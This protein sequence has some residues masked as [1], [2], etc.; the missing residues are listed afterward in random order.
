MNE[1][2]A[3]SSRKTL[4]NGGQKASIRPVA[5]RL[6]RLALGCAL[7]S[8][9]ATT[10]VALVARLDFA[11]QAPAL[12]VA[13]ET[14]AAITAS[15]AAFLLLGRFRRT[16][17]LDELILSAGLTLLAISNFAFAAVPA[18]FDLHSN[19][20]SLWG[21]LFTGTLA[22]LLIAVAALLPRRRLAAGPRWPLVVYGS[23]VF[24]GVIGALL[25]AAFQNR[26]PPGVTASTTGGA[27]HP[28]LVVHPPVLTLQLVL[29][30]L[31]LLAAL[32]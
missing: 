1:R 27:S 15:A 17:F 31:Y 21:M 14:T 22:A 25:L 6:R 26:L 19:R 7:G 2:A 12:H 28:H 8:A 4:P 32:G 5:L 24:V 23:V 20:A 18:A 11:Y 29:A 16:G 30:L 3:G 13:L 9:G 10:A